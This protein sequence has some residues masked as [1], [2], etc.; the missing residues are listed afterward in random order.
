MGPTCMLH[1][2]LAAR[3]RTPKL[4]SVIVQEAL[5]VD[6]LGKDVVARN[7]YESETIILLGR[8]LVRFPTNSCMSSSSSIRHES[9]CSPTPRTHQS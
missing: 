9:P 7:S 8:P 2:Y 6:C 5:G 1:W 3:W 4:P